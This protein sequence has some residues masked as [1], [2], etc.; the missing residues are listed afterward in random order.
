[1]LKEAGVPV[2]EGDVVT[3][4]EGAQRVARRLAVPVTLKPLDGNQGKGVTVA[5]ATPDDVALAFEFARQY[6]RR[7]I[8]ERHVEGRDYRVLVACGRVAA[9]SCRQIG[10]AHV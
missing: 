6:G 1:M 4:V 5:C 8:V 3:T 7:V 2:P 10:R 9:A